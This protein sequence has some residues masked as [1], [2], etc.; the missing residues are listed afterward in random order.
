[1][2]SPNNFFQRK[3]TLYMDTALLEKKFET[4]GAR[5][6]FREFRRF[7]ENASISIDIRKDKEGEFYDIQTRPEREVSV[8]DLQK[9]DRHLLLMTRDSRGN[10]QKFLCGH[11]ERA[12]FTCAIPGPVSS[13]F[14]AKQALKPKEVVDAEIRGDVKVRDLQKRRRRLS[15][16]GKIIRQGEFMF[17]PQPDMIVEETGLSIILRNEPMRRGRGGNAHYAE[18]LFRRGGVTVYV[19]HK[20]PNGLTEKQYQE[21]IKRN[22]DDAKI[23]WSIMKR[24]PEAFVMGR[25][26]HREHATVDLKNIWHKVALNTEDQAPWARNVAFLD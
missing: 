17:I 21:R 9:K 16:G 24:N 12:W 3:E 4:I 20:A 6:K 7:N 2:C 18:Y 13:V 25:I 14:Q 8:L 1:M 5:V 23:N 22:P 15:T 10:P 11:D 26:T 19:S